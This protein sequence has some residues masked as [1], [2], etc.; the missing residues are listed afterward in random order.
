MKKQI[1]TRSQTYELDTERLP[2]TLEGRQGH[3]K[4][5]PRGLISQGTKISATNN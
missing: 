2:W 3:R 5:A 4:K 1:E